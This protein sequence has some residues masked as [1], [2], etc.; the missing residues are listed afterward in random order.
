MKIPA[1]DQD[2]GL[3][4]RLSNERGRDEDPEREKKTVHDGS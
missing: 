2:A 3:G 1:N 4:G